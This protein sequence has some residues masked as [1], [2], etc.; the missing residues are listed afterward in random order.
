ML[1]FANFFQHNGFGQEAVPGYG[2]T[3][4]LVNIDLTA[5]TSIGHGNIDEVPRLQQAVIDKVLEITVQQTKRPP[6]RAK[7]RPVS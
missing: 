5:D 4:E 3:G 7:R 1:R 2:F 6:A